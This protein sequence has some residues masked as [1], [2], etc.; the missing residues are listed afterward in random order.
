MIL[1]NLMTNC[2]PPAQAC[3]YSEH[4]VLVPSIDEFVG[5]NWRLTVFMGWA[6]HSKI[7]HENGLT[8]TNLLGID[9]KE[10]NCSIWSCNHQMTGIN[11]RHE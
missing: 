7:E 5:S 2:D 3:S 10:E 11:D 8:T 6:C 9:K 4:P 1:I